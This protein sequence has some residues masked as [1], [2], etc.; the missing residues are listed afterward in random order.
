MKMG[1]ELALLV[2]VGLMAMTVNA[3]AYID[4]GTG[5]VV[6]TAI[7]GFFAAVAYTFRKYMYKI[8]DMFVG[9][10]TKKNSDDTR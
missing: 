9:A 6:T 2:F 4:P 8:K 10:K 5:S 1:R 7:L 3:H